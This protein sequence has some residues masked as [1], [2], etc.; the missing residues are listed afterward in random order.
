MPQRAHCQE[1]AGT[2]INKRTMARF[3]GNRLKHL[4]VHHV[5]TLIDSEL[6]TRPNRGQV[7][8]LASAR[9]EE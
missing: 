4:V 6:G 3:G 7:M 9:D 8:R 1:E 5:W 2:A